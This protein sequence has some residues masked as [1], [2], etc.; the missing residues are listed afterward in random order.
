MLVCRRKRHGDEQRM[1]EGMKCVSGGRRN[2]REEE[3]ETYD[4]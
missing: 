2:E 4:C 3:D 1:R